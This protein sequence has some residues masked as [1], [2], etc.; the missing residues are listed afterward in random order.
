[1][2]AGVG[3]FYSD[4]FDPKWVSFQ[5]A[6]TVD[7]TPWNTE[8]ELRLLF[9]F[10]GRPSTSRDVYLQPAFFRLHLRP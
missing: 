5:P 7:S 9:S 10:L 4:D 2:D 6:L 1:M 8:K 3:Q